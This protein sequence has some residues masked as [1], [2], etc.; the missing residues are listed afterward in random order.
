VPE[1]AEWSGLSGV[2]PWL[3]DGWEKAAVSA[4]L[5]DL[6]GRARPYGG[7]AMLASTAA[8]LFGFG[9]EQPTKPAAPV[10]P[11]RRVLPEAAPPV[12]LVPTK[13]PGEEWTPADYAALLHQFER[14]TTGPAKQKALSAHDE[15]GKAWGYSANSIRPYLVEA[16]KQRKSGAAVVASTV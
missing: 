7:V 16:R 14:L 11:L 2:L 4:S 10:V 3:A 12:C 6:R 15:L 5:D 13:R 9:V 8:E 1:V